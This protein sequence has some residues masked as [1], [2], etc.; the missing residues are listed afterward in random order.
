MK[1]RTWFAGAIAASLLVP[2]VYAQDKDEGAARVQ[3]EQAMQQALQQARL[4]E[5]VI[6]MREQASAGRDYDATYRSWLKN[7][8]ASRP[9]EALGAMLQAG[10]W[11][12]RLGET[13]S[14]L[15]YTPVA[16]CRIIDTRAVGAGGPIVP[17]TDRN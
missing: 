16:P 7:D 15:V 2:A 6:A 5:S 3:Q 9:A 8:L 11:E 17:G 13:T 14:Q 12:P 10:G 1:L 4:A